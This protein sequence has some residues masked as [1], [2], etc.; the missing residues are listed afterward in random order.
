LSILVTGSTPRVP[1]TLTLDTTPPT[2]QRWY[3]DREASAIT[4]FLYFN[5]PVLLTNV[6]HISV[7]R[8]PKTAAGK[9][10]SF[11][12]APMTLYANTSRSANDTA[13]VV[14]WGLTYSEYNRRVSFKLLNYC[15]DKYGGSWCLTNNLPTENLFAFL[16]QTSSPQYGYFLTLGVAVVQDFALVPNAAQAIDER[17]QVLEGGPGTTSFLF[18]TSSVFPGN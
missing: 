16:N 10:A 15:T 12:S 2:L 14:P 3:L 13:A 6:S 17:N 9:P 18:P 5:E 7:Y 8:N 11:G 1:D 4:A